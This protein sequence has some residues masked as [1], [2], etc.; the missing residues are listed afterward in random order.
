MSNHLSSNKR[1][2]YTFTYDWRRDP[3]ENAVL[4]VP[5]LSWTL[6]PWPSCPDS[7]S[8]SRT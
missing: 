2:C 6:A 4:Y 5:P 8:D 3:L 7:D 1:P